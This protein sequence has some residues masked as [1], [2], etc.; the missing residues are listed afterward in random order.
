MVKTV[1]AWTNDSIE[2]LKGCFLCTDWDTFSDE[3]NVTE[4]TTDYIK[5]CVDTVIPKKTIKV[6]P[7]N[8]PYITKEVK[9][10]INRKK[11]AFK[12][13]LLQLKT[14]QKELNKRLKEAREHHRKAREE[15]FQTMNSKK[16]WDSMKTTTNK[17]LINLYML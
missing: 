3:D 17:K 12:T 6:Y 1:N 7:N 2:T 4:V 8:K 14:V 15:I 11:Q 9:D 5:F 16:L 10:C 13:N